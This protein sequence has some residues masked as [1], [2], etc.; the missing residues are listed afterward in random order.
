MKSVACAALALAVVL[1]L[2]GRAAPG[3][4]VIRTNSCPWISAAD[5]VASEMGNLRLRAPGVK[6]RTAGGAQIYES[7]VGGSNSVTVVRG[8]IIVTAGS[9]INAPVANLAA[10]ALKTAH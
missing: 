3:D 2:S 10:M 1:P 5:S 9:L 6:V 8:P 7:T 4:G